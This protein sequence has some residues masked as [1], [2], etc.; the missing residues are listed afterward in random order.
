MSKAPE[1]TEFEKALE[2]KAVKETSS[3][4]KSM[5]FL[6]TLTGF[7]IMLIQGYEK[8][9]QAAAEIYGRAPNEYAKSEM[10]KRREDA[11][12]VPATL[13]DLCV[14]NTMLIQLR[15]ETMQNVQAL[16]LSQSRLVQVLIEK[17]VVEEKD[18]MKGE[19]DADNSGNESGN[20]AGDVE[21]ITGNKVD[22]NQA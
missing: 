22:K 15:N 8:E 2:E 17:G 21:G 4:E 20:V 19:V 5:E 10:I 13:A 1:K 14:L 6:S 16:M 7:E 11:K 9:D 3:K 18:L 12:K